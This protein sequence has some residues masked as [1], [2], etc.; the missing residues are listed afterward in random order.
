MAVDDIAQ[1]G[2]RKAKTTKNTRMFAYRD[3]NGDIAGIILQARLE[4]AGVGASLG[5]TYLAICQCPR[6]SGKGRRQN[7]TLCSG[8]RPSGGD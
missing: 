4:Q 8:G 7:T 1:K 5:T 2:A 6:L 3:A